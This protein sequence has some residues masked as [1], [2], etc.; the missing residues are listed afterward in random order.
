MTIFTTL[1]INSTDKTSEK[2]NMGPIL[3]VSSFKYQNSLKMFAKVEI[4]LNII[5]LLIFLEKDTFS[6]VQNEFLFDYLNSCLFIMHFRNL[7][8]YN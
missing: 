8:E 3:L 5:P 6:S 1:Q 2:H 7:P 4:F